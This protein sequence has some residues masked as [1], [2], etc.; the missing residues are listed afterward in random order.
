MSDMTFPELP[1]AGTSGWSG[2]DTS[3]DRAEAEDRDGITS[4]RQQA[5]LTVIAASANDGVTWAELAASYKWHH[6][7]AS[8]VLSVLHK[9]GH[10]VRL[11]KRRGRS[12]VYVLPEWV[13]GRETS[14][15][16]ANKKKC[17]HCGGSL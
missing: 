11:T 14:E 8:S 6:G 1:Y 16:A 3:R 12:A 5:A 4:H 10:I 9:T 13:Q 2:S 17:P 7:Q 15:Y